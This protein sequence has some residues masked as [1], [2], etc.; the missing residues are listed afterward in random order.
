MLP[1]CAVP[2][3]LAD[4]SAL[5]DAWGFVF[6]PTAAGL[7]LWLAADGLWLRHPHI[8]PKGE[9]VNFVAG[10]V[11]YRR[12][13]GGREPLLRAVGKRAAG[14]WLVDATAGW[15]RDS[16]LLAHGGWTVQLVEQQ[17]AL[18]A[19]LADGLARATVQQPAFAA[20]LRLAWAEGRTWLQ[21][22]AFP[23]PPTVIY[24]DPL[25]PPTRKTALVKKDMQLL[26]ALAGVPDPT[27]D[28][29]LLATA[30]QIARRV[31][32]KRPVGASPLDGQPPQFAVT[33]PSIRFDVYLSA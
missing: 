23:T 12:Q 6:T 10:S 9:Q 2:D 15:G 28:A 33:G 27:Q 24:L 26:Q 4:A 22:A 5:A 19:L 21:A 29:A 11:G 20:R 3:R 8:A 30:R 13:Q 31:V 1:I 18:A 32:V 17:P 16:A 7:H 14:D 25:F